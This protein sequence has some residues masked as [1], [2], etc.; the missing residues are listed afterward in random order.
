MI[1]EDDCDSLSFLTSDS[2]ARLLN[3][4]DSP[5]CLKKNIMI[6]NKASFY[7][8][9]MDKNLQSRGYALKTLTMH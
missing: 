3:V 5:P 9:L 6:K 8:E 7:T 2:I 1:K 4:S